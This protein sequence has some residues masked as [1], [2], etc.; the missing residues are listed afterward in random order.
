MSELEDD[1]NNIYSTLFITGAKIPDARRAIQEGNTLRALDSIT[2]AKIAFGRLYS[3]PGIREQFVKMVDQ[4]RPRGE[5]E[6]LVRT[7]DECINLAKQFDSSE[8][9]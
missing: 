3:D 6:K 7:L 8:L 2:Q 9:E 4:K 1:I 5:A